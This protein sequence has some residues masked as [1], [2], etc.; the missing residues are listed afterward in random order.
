MPLVAI[1]GTLTYFL[2]DGA[3]KEVSSVMRC[4]CEGFNMVHSELPFADMFEGYQ[5]IQRVERV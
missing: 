3:E 5:G 2:L 1:H 4:A